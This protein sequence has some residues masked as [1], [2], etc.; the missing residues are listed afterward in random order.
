MRGRWRV[1]L[2]MAWLAVTL[3]SFDAPSTRAAPR[4]GGEGSTDPAFDWEKVPARPPRYTYPVPPIESTKTLEQTTRWLR[5]ALE[6]Y[7][8][9]VRP[10]AYRSD[11]RD[12]RF[13]GCS[14]EWSVN[15]ELGND[16]TRLRSHELHLG[17]IT[18]ARGHRTH[19]NVDL[20]QPPR[21]KERIFEKGREKPSTPLTQTYVQLPVRN[22]DHIS[23]RISWALRHAAR[24]CA[25][26][27]R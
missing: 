10:T 11:I 17:T 4:V 9:N 26:S 5:W 16:M 27:T 25:G 20:S 22:E 15:E 1:I 3:A 13:R 21:V 6:R 12:V 18:A 14:M 23:D 2:V 24:L 19:T 7:G 8:S